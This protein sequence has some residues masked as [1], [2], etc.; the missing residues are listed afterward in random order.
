M[1]ILAKVIHW[2]GLGLGFIDPCILWALEWMDASRRK[3]TTVRTADELRSVDGP[4]ELRV[5]PISLVRGLC[6]LVSC[7]CFGFCLCCSS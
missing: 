1:V 7:L 4:E 3:S 6:T 5:D 2:F